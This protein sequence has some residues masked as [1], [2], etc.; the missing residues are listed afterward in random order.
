MTRVD[1][2]EVGGE[3]HGVLRE[4][5]DAGES[6]GELAAVGLE[7]GVVRLD[8]DPAPVGRGSRGCAVRKRLANF[9]VVCLLGAERDGQAAV[10]RRAGSAVR[11]GAAPAYWRE[12]GT[13]GQ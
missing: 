13:F 1:G 3:Q 8:C 10:A 6:S 11:G 5:E 7:L 12:A 2:A 9:G 4:A